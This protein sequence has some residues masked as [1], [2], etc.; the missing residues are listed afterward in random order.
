MKALE[1]PLRVIFCVRSYPIIHDNCCYLASKRSHVRQEIAIIRHEY[2]KNVCLL[3]MSTTYL[4]N[5][6]N[7]KAT[8]SFFIFLLVI[9]FVTATNWYT[10]YNIFALWFAWL[11]LDNKR[12][13]AVCIFLMKSGLTLRYRQSSFHLTWDFLWF[14]GPPHSH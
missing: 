8:Y 6:S 1:K 2:K 12:D 11:V 5:V 14:S 9:A 4:N 7:C 3:Q 10:F 13:D